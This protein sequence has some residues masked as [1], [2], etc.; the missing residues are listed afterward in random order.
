MESGI[1]YEPCTQ[2]HLKCALRLLVDHLPP[3]RRREFERALTTELRRS[4]GVVNTIWI[5]RRG[6]QVLAAAWTAVDAALV[7]DLWPPRLA[8][9]LDAAAQFSGRLLE[10]IVEWARRKGLR[11]AL[12]LLDP[13]DAN[14]LEPI[15]APLGFRRIAPID[16]LAINLPAPAPG[17]DLAEDSSH[18]S[19][20]F[21]T[22]RE[23]LGWDRF[24]AVW[25]ECLRESRDLPELWD[26]LS[27]ED[28]S[29]SYPRHV[30]RGFSGWRAGTLSGQE[31]PCSV[32]ILSPGG[33]LD[34]WTISFLGLIPSARGEGLG[35]VVLR[36]ALDWTSKQGGRRVELSVDRRNERALRLY[37]KC[38]FERVNER[39]LFVRGLVASH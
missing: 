19:P 22:N 30:S 31:Q 5:A 13:S 26:W 29:R 12:M 37:T 20:F 27:L 24:A 38:G 39:I 18:E 6:D 28:C 35:R 8:V 9:G 4:L 1:R 2:P 11:I 15:L 10:E 32:V 17:L 36:D 21:W 7:L 23:Q 16:F 34:H 25:L 3:S 33:E 14:A